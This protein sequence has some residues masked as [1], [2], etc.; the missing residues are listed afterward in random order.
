MTDWKAKEHESKNKDKDESRHEHEIRHYDKQEDKHE[1]K[2]VGYDT[3]QHDRGHAAKYAVSVDNG[4]TWSTQK[5]VTGSEAGQIWEGETNDGGKTYQAY[6]KFTVPSIVVSPP[7][8]PG[9]NPPGP[10]TPTN[11]PLLGDIDIINK[12]NESSDNIKKMVDACKTQCDRDV[13]QYWGGTVAFHILGANELPSKGHWYCGFFNNSDEAG[14]LGWHDSGPNNE[15][16]IKIFT[17]EAERFGENPSV[18]LSHEVIESIGDT[19]ANTTVKGV[20]ESGRACIYFREN[21]DPVEALT[22]DV[23]GVPM[24]DFVTPSWFT[25]NPASTSKFD[26]LQKCTKP[27]QIL[28]GGYMEISYDNGKTWSEVDKMSKL[29]A[30]HKKAHSRWALY[31]K[32]M[33]ERQRSTFQTK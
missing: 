7:G 30:R 21:C 26:F 2:H 3:Q 23:D 27:F 10:P 28:K 20:D 8:P 14:V 17:Q 24:S 4:K 25:Q 5:V 29:A 32:P 6:R 33:H 1:D 31:K 11:I 13:A 22:Y 16:L 18:T 12:S 15:P 9:P 19:D